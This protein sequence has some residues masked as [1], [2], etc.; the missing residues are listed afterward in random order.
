MLAFFDESILI[1]IKGDILFFVPLCFVPLRLIFTY[2]SY[3]G[4]VCCTYER[5]GFFHA[6]LDRPR[7]VQSIGTVRDRQT[8]THL[9]LILDK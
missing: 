9:V 4:F 3:F 7:L 1:L 5:A 2:A 6:P 8:T